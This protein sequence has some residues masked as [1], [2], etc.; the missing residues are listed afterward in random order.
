MANTDKDAIKKNWQNNDR[1]CDADAP[2]RR[3]VLR[4]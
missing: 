2:E 1:R 3:D 4:V